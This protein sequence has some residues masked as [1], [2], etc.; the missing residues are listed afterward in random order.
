[1]FGQLHVV[2]RLGATTRRCV[3]AGVG[4][5]GIPGV[6]VG[7]EGVGVEGVGVEGLIV[8]KIVPEVVMNIV[9]IAV[10]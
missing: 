9:P 1:M 2:G 4:V 7:V 6:G 8:G 10:G 3:V 5:G